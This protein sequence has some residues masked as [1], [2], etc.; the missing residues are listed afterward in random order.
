[1]T[2]YASEPASYGLSASLRDAGFKLGRLRTGTPP[3]LIGSTI[4][5][6]GLDI[7]AGDDPALPFSLMNTRVE[8]QD[9]QTVTYKT[10][11]NA[12]SHDVIRQNLDKT[13]H[14]KEEVKGPRYC[15]SME[16]KILKFGQKDSHVVWLEPEGYPDDTDLIYPNGLSMT[17]PEEAQ[18][19]VMRTIPGLEKVEMVRPGYGVEYDHVDPR[20]LRPTLETKRIKGL[21][22]AGQIN[23]TTGYEEAASQGIVAGINAAASVLGRDPLVLNRADSFIGV[24]I[25]DLVTKGADEPCMCI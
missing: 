13:V 7:Q 14:V 24:M 17:I 18:L 12:A 8:N 25:D 15:P 6:E 4:N 9:N 21:F 19:A 20:E 11:T 22:L 23:G 5:Y 16:S 2:P 10:S 3:R 1:L